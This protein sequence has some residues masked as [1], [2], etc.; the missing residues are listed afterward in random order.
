MKTSNKLWVKIH[1]H[2]EMK[3]IRKWGY[4]DKPI[5]MDFFNNVPLVRTNVIYRTLEENED[6]FIQS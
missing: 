1:H 6:N 5:N 4:P 3:I 2:I